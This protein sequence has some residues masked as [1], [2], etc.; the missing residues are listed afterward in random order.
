MAKKVIV[1]IFIALVI[2]SAI[3][4][5]WDKR[6]VTTSSDQAYQAYKIGEAT[7]KK[8]YYN[9]AIP[10]F[11]RA[12]SIDT[13]FAAAYASLGT[14]YFETGRQ[15]EAKQMFEKAMSKFALIT[16]R[17]QILITIGQFNI[18]K[19]RPAA[20][21]AIDEYIEKY[22]DDFYGLRF[23]AEKEQRDGNF[24]GAISAYEK[25]IDMDPGDALAYN[26]LGYLNYYNRN[27]EDAISYIKKYSM[28]AS[29]EANPHD[30]YGEI[31]MYIGQYDEAIKEFE[32]ADKI[33]NDLDF[34]LSHLGS[35]H[36]ELGRYR[37]AIGYFERAKEFARSEAYEARAEEQIAYSL[38]RTGD[39]D[40]ALKLINDL[41]SKH[42]EWY[43]VVAY[44]G[45]INAGSGNIEIAYSA[46]DE[47][48]EMLDKADSS[49]SSE[50]YKNTII[51][52]RESVR[53]KIGL[54]EKDYNKAIEAYSQI[55]ELSQL[56]GL[57]MFRYL[58]GE[59]YYQAGELEKARNILLTNLADNPNHPFS[60]FT[61]SQI[62][63]GTGATDKQE[64]ALLTYLSVMSGADDS[65]EDVRTA[66]QQLDSLTE[67]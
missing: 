46:I 7:N 42:S 54:V 65:V 14:L 23:L 56:P 44:W 45:I 13:N 59:A 17:E 48:N 62:Y 40:Q 41:H 39:N 47:L 22:P 29:Q 67:L 1:I 8:L 24:D 4:A 57:M 49:G 28:I 25:L 60:L 64:Q 53:G 27:F 36:R 51:I 20:E 30:S 19:N 58:L 37:D 12:I 15:E 9:E 16:E 21:E 10:H 3:Y 38:Y 55:I 52:Y 32:T 63:K 5:L 50:E 18:N 6:E 61:L 31:L 2:F 66:R 34:V 43:S 11:E 33:K 35:V 26:M